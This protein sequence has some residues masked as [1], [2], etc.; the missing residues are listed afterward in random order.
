LGVISLVPGLLCSKPLRILKSLVE[1]SL[2]ACLSI[3]AHK[4]IGIRHFIPHRAYSRRC[5]G[6]GSSGKAMAI[7]HSNRIR[8]AITSRLHLLVST[9]IHLSS[10]TLTPVESEQARGNRSVGT[11]GPQHT[12]KT[13]RRSPRLTKRRSSI[14]T[15]RQ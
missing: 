4:S 2:R 10:S 11:Q 14:R 13:G 8:I 7:H 1:F 6:S 3:F 9:P 12:R 15:Y 5:P